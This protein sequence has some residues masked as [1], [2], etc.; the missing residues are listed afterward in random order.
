MTE[1]TQ[2]FDAGLGE[3][4]N[5]ADVPMPE[6]HPAPLLWRVLIAPRR[7]KKMSAGGLIIAHAARDA[8]QHLNYIGQVIAMGELAYKSDLFKDMADVPKVGDWVAYGRYAGQPLLYRGY[9]FLV[10][11]DKEILCRITDPEALTIYL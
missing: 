1:Q 10:V 6:D 9:R 3:W 4:T 5:E 11:N 2:D 8:E 7:P